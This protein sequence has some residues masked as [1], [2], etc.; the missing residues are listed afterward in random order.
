MVKPLMPYMTERFDK[1]AIRVFVVSSLGLLG[2]LL[3]GWINMSRNPLLP[4]SAAVAS[5]APFQTG[6]SHH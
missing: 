4:P 1:W 5:S 2:S 3:P 6:I